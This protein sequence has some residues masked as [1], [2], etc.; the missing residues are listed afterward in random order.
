MEMQNRIKTRK[1]VSRQYMYIFQPYD[2]FTK[3]NIII[4]NYYAF[5][6]LVL[7]H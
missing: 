5:G 6:N 2:F 4:I 1:P 7:S 3:Y